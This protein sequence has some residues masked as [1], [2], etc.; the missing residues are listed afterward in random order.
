VFACLWELG[1]WQLRSNFQGMV[2]DT[3]SS[4]TG[5]H[6]GASTLTEE[7]VTRNWLHV[8]TTMHVSLGCPMYPQL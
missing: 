3:T 2:F 1:D 5:L 8:D 4:N 6:L 7:V